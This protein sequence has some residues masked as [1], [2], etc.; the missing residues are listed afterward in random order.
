MGYKSSNL[1][2]KEFIRD[3]Y[4]IK[5]LTITVLA[6]NL[7]RKESSLWQD[8]LDKYTKE[9][10]ER[11]L[12]NGRCTVDSQCAISMMLMTGLYDDKQV[13]CNQLIEVVESDEYKLTC[14]MVGIQYIYDALSESV[15]G[16]RSWFENGATTLW[17][18]WNGQDSGSHNHHMFSGV[19]AWFYKSLMGISPDPEYPAFE[20]I[21]LKLVFIKELGFVK[22]SMTTV[23]GSIEAEWHYDD[24]KFIYTVDLPEGI[25]AR[26]CNKEL[27]V[28][29][30][31]FYV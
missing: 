1:T 21:E 7:A 22:G 10:K 16:Y 28:G 19:I 23:K 5:A 27:T 20:E 18:K 12:D 3:F 11:Y 2:P 15:P 9:F 13:L 30:N 26:F 17:E 6:Q 8:K 25:R 4:L 24:G 14:G 29:E 31:I